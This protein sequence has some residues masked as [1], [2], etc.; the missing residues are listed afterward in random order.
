MVVA[1]NNHGICCLAPAQSDTVISVPVPSL[2]IV[3][4][5]IL[6]LKL[7]FNLLETMTYFE[8]LHKLQAHDDYILKCLLPL[9]FID[10]QRYHSNKLSAEQFLHKTQILVN[11][12]FIFR[13]LQVLSGTISRYL[14]TAS[15]DHTAKIWNADGLTLGRA[16]TGQQRWVLDCVFSMDASSDTTARLQM[17]STGEAIRVYQG[18]HKAAVC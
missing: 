8:P 12:V 9:E 2:C 16:L 17:M 10:P 1:A 13:I 6:I 3:I 11:A 4:C 5:N 15:S 18:H 14:A 7:A